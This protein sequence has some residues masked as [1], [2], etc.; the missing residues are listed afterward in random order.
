MG[1][2]EPSVQFWKE[3]STVLPINMNLLNL[4]SLL[5]QFLRTEDASHPFWF[6]GSRGV[7]QGRWEVCEVV[8]SFH[9]LQRALVRSR[10]MDSK[11]SVP[12]AV[13]LLLHVSNMACPS[14]GWEKMLH[15]AERLCMIFLS[16]HE[17]ETNLNVTLKYIF[18]HRLIWCIESMNIART[19]R[20][21]YFC[22]SSELK[23]SPYADGLT[24]AK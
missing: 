9:H 5:R 6:W 2:K 10:Y 4:L 13:S 15:L 17:I 11:F 14:S 12:N 1:V 3:S 23:D 16:G 24:C 20:I 21:V 8:L 7:H 22:T 18:L 19:L